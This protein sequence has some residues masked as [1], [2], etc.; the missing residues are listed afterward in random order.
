LEVKSKIITSK[1]LANE[2]YAGKGEQFWN[3]LIKEADLNGDGE[4]AF[5]FLMR[6]NFLD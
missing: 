3:D 1:C 4:V 2:T 6:V 5:S